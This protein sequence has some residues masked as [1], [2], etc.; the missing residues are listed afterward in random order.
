[1]HILRNYDCSLHFRKSHFSERKAPVAAAKQIVGRQVEKIDYNQLVR[2]L[3]VAGSGIESALLNFIRD[4]DIVH[5]PQNSVWIASAAHKDYFWASLL[6]ATADL[7]FKPMW[8]FLKYFVAVGPFALPDYKQDAFLNAEFPT[9]IPV[10]Q[11]KLDEPLYEWP[12]PERSGLLNEDNF[13]DQAK[14]FDAYMRGLVEVEA[15]YGKL[16]GLEMSCQYT[17]LNDW[18]A[19]MCYSGPAI[20][21]AKWKFATYGFPALATDEGILWLQLNYKPTE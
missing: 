21:N 19:S 16:C 20:F 9:H 15:I 5:Q 4:R 2:V 18:V 14:A 1:M 12:L 6:N 3:V 7:G 10:P 13:Q 17:T 8:Y 11:L